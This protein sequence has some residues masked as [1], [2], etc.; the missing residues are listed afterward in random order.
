MHSGEEKMW[1]AVIDRAI[2]DAMDKKLNEVE[3]TEAFNWLFFGGI[4]F[5]IV[6]DFANVAPNAARKKWL[7]KRISRAKKFK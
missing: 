4:D 7:R 6:C 1:Q 2:S 5:E 3:K